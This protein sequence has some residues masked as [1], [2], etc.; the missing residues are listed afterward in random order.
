MLTRWLHKSPPILDFPERVALPHLTNNEAAEALDLLRLLVERGQA[1][2]Y[3]QNY[4][5]A[6]D[7]PRWTVWIKPTEE[8]PG[9]SHTLETWAISVLF[10]PATEESCATQ[11]G[12]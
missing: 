5:P 4:S 12:P 8:A 11:R 2:V 6:D 7:L 9:E 1:D 3:T 10:P